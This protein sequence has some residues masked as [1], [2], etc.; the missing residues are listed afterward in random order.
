MNSGMVSLSV[1]MFLATISGA[2][3]VLLGNAKVQRAARRGRNLSGTGAAAQ[4]NS[5]TPPPERVSSLTALQ[6]RDFRLLWIGQLISNVGT[7]MQNITIN[8]S[9]LI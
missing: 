8:Y 1:L 4:L 3:A 7:Q 9:H 6:Y 5:P 2:V